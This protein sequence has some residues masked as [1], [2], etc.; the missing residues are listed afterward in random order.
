MKIPGSS[1]GGVTELESYLSWF[2]ELAKRK[3]MILA[4]DGTFKYIYRRSFYTGST[5]VD[6]S[7]SFK[8]KQLCGI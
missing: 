8:N 7:K 6:S 2:R 4:T 3:D 1:P 5:P